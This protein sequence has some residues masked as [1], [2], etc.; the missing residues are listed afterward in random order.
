ML[1]H[2]IEFSRPL[3]K[4][5]PKDFKTTVKKLIRYNINTPD[6][7]DKIWEAEG[8]N[9]W[10]DYENKYRY[11]I[12]LVPDGAEVLD[13]GCGVGLLLR[14]LKE[15]KP[16]I[17]G[18]GA[19]ISAKAIDFVKKHGFGGVVGG[20]PTLS[21]PSGAFDIVLATEV[22]EHLSEPDEAVRE[23]VR[24]MKSTGKAILT[25]PDDCLGPEDE[26]QHLRKYTMESFRAQLAPHFDRI[27]LISIADFN[28]NFL[29]AVC[30]NP[31]P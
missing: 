16:R 15:V 7:W 22:L 11:I 2:C 28:Y 21:L 18:T 10:R 17:R 8:E 9:T 31:K 3:L 4:I 1:Q 14:K 23:V 12:S 26:V 6:Y 13:I 29:V 5:F 27:E 30:E 24:L 20:F 25:V 19:D